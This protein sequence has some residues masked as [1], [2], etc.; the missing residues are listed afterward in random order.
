MHPIDKLCQDFNVTRYQICK[1][2]GLSRT[3][4]DGLVRRNTSVEDMKLGTLIK[5]SSALKIS[6]HELIDKLL[7]Y[8]KS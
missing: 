2:A 6:V 5:I 4:L 7:Q 1:D 8:T 3:S